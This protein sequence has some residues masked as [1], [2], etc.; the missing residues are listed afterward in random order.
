M[1][2]SSA[3]TLSPRQI[4]LDAIHH[5]DHVL[6]GQ[7]PIHDFVHH[8]TLHGFQH[9][10]FEQAL[11]EFT[12]LTGIS[13]YQSDEQFRTFYAQGRI[14]DD[15]ID[16][17]LA[18]QFG[19]ALD[20]G[21]CTING[22]IITR[23][24]LYRL[25][26]LH[27][28]RTLTPAQFDWQV[29]ELGVLVEPSSNGDTPRGLWEALLAKLE[30]Q[31]LDLHPEDLFDL[32]GEQ[33]QQWLPQLAGAEQQM[34]QAHTESLAKLFS[35][36]GDNLTVRGLLLALTGKDILDTVR[37]LLIRLCASLLD[38]GL[39]AWRLPKRQE[40]GLY[41][42]WRESL[43]YDAQPVFQELNDWQ[44]VT[45]V[46][47]A[48]A[49]DA[50]EQ[51]LAALAVPES[52]W[53]GYLQRLALELPGWSGLINWRQTHPDY[54]ADDRTQPLLADY[55]AIRLTLDRLYAE[56]LC[57]QQWHC[58]AH[59]DKL[60]GYFA[61]NLAE[62][63]VR[64]ALFHGQLPEYLALAAQSL[65]N[66]AA[67]D[68]QAWQTLAERIWTW[69]LSPL[70][71]SVLSIYNQGWRLFRLCQLL[72]LTARDVLHFESAQLL[73][74]LACIDAFS[75]ADRSVICLNAYER[76]YRQ[77][78]LQA[79]HAN[80]NRGRWAQRD[81]RPEAQIVF[82]MDD[83]EEGI[84]RHLEELNPAIETLG[85]AGFFGVPMNYQ[86]LDD[87]KLTALCPVVVVPAH[88]VQE[89]SQPGQDKVLARHRQ[90]HNLKQRIAHLLH[91]GLRRDVLLAYPV[92]NAM[93]PFTLLGLLAKSFIPKIQHQLLVAAAQGMAPDV[94]SQ[95]HF[96][97]GNPETP[98][99]P[100]QPR[101]GFTDQ[102]QAERIAGFL[103][104][105]GLTY[106]FAE[107]VVLMG[108]GSMSQNNPH[109]SAYDCGACSGR[110]GGPNARLFAAMANRPEVRQLLV[111]RG[112]I[113]PADT[114]FIGAEHNT[115]DEDI[116]WYDS[117][118]VPTERQPA[119]NQFMREMQHAQRMSAHERCRRLASA[120]RRPQ[121]TQALRHF[122]NRSADFSQVR[123]ELGHATNAAALVGRRSLTQGAFFDRRLFLISYDPSQDPE[124]TVLEGILLA[125]GPVGAG[126]NLEYYFSTVNNERLGCGS[127]VPHNLTGFCAVMEGAGSDLRT[128]L[129]RQMIEIH[130]AM[131]LQIIVEASTTV[132][133]QIYGR[134]ESLREL[135]GGGWVHLSAKDPHSGEISVFQRGVGFVRWQPADIAL[136]LRDNSPD[137]YRDETQPVAPMLIKQA[138]LTGVI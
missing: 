71:P 47:P 95:L 13:C 27:D 37:P 9:L 14:A 134:Q 55:L 80:H 77:A 67:R 90:G 138:D 116:T 115:C 132:L 36:V 28:L 49:V 42:A 40:L 70:A 25:A 112:I 35:Q 94:P 133:E 7:A 78:L 74:C 63:A 64:Q 120:P 72:G 106:G 104:N 57:R 100:Q 136:P 29:H 6:P 60:R 51:Q 65:M 33:I 75:E 79:L 126:I 92:I 113:V 1:M 137:C 22:K 122:L 26:L 2:A 93:A 84:R 105:T 16:A 87:T 62:F 46:L 41:Q 123:P 108:H 39:A 117:A 85:A 89:C 125:V 20:T 12:Q 127:K 101:L 52:R 98:A 18:Q 21:I 59:L 56:Q 5:L 86:G 119:F 68:K 107:L 32:S 38:E 69:Q 129:P 54:Q 11:A 114:W 45:A 102:E 53:A 61:K 110:H 44:A 128:G 131:R 109:L 97:A 124:G 88:N 23:D 135:I 73:D 8:N 58:E 43:I 17:A 81:S 99:T 121:P 24:M 4:I 66:D 83:R 111:E 103:R 10:P 130:E 31:A 34:H 3:S 76:H 118:V 82:C 19:D 30:L 50:I 96:T 91:H 48:D 15:D